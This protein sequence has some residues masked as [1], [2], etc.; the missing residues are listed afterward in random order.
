MS[1]FQTSIFDGEKYNS[2]NNSNMSKKMS[3]MPLTQKTVDRLSKY[4]LEDY[5]HDV[6]TLGLVNT[7]EFICPFVKKYPD[8]NK[9]LDVCKLGKLYE[10]GLALQDKKLKRKSGQYYTPEDVS[11]IMSEW[12]M[13]LDGE[14]ICDVACGTGNLILSYF[15]KI[16]KEQVLKLLRDGKVYLYDSDYIALH[17]CKTIILSKYGFEYENSIHDVCCDFLNSKVK[18]PENSKVISNPPYFAF[19]QIPKEWENS[20][21]QCQTKEF[22]S[23]FM[24]KIL[25]QSVSSVIITPYSFIGGG[26]FYELR[27]LMNNYSGHIVSFDNVPGNIFDGKK[28]GIFNTNMAN[29]VRAAITVTDNKSGKGYRLTPLIRF[30]KTERAKLLDCSV[31][32]TF[33][34]ARKQLVSKENPMYYKLFVQ[35][36]DVFGKWNAKSDKVLKELTVKSGQYSISVPTTCRYYTVASHQPMN[37]SGQM[38]VYFDDADK[39][40][41]VYCLVNSSFAYWHWRLYD[42]GITYPKSLF[43][44]MPVFF[45]ILSDEDKV[46]F[47]KTASDL[48]DNESR[49]IVRKNNVGIQENI[50]FPKRYRDKIN[51]RFVKILGAKL[52]AK[53]FDVIHSNMALEVSV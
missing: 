39:F 1:V 27:H 30:K 46:F 52:D 49:Y 4:T 26:K 2:S 15:S 22:Y 44:N 48:I 43:M 41:Y 33:L 11:N 9:V 14:N 8:K 16:G 47:K 29:S 37:R 53:E 34:D 50:K 25:K 51:E 31:L 32:E 40:N 19:S 5:C 36:S 24:E 28:Q 21:I 17:I 38:T 23:S 3:E 18:L 6:N 20:D 42:G 10:I 7:W 13:K 12:F 45:D 35:L